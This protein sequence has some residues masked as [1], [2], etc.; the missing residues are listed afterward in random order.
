MYEPS[1]ASR[2]LRWSGGKPRT[3]AK[4]RF[5]QRRLV[6]HRRYDACDRRPMIVAGG[7]GGTVARSHDVA[8]YTITAV[9]A[10]MRG[11]E[12]PRRCG[13]SRRRSIRAVFA[14]GPV[15]D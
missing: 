1:A 15:C 6:G 11:L 12:R 4:L 10:T 9:R 8:R 5:D 2:T 13:A 7:F 14:G 3:L